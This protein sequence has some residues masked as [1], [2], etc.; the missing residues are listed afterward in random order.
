[1]ERGSVACTG[2]QTRHQ[3]TVVA[4]R[5]FLNLN[6]EIADK[7]SNAFANALSMRMDVPLTEPLRLSGQSAGPG[8]GGAKPQCK[9][10]IGRHFAAIRTT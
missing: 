2:R 8:A 9:A 5:L 1:M 7:S 3:S 10:R 6:H 4:R